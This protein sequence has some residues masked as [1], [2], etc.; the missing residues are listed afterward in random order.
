MGLSCDSTHC[1]L[2]GVPALAGV[3]ST[4]PDFQGRNSEH[5]TPGF[6]DFLFSILT[7][8]FLQG[9][10][11]Y[12]STKRSDRLSAIISLSLKNADS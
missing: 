11:V 7:K 10:H 9:G 6:F 2:E 5:F 4:S 1:Y 3:E 8:R 12:R